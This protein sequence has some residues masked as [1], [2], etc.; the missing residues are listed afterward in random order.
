VLRALVGTKEFRQSKGAKLRDPAED[1]VASYRALG[2]T[3]AKP[4]ADGDAANAM[5]WQTQVVG[6][7]PM[8]W[9][10]PDGQPLDNQAWATPARALASMDV[11]WSL[12]GGWW[13]SKG[14]AYQSAAQWAPALP[15]TFAEVVDHLARRVHGTPSNS[16]VLKAACIAVGVDPGMQISADHMAL[17][18]K[19]NRL[20]GVLLDHPRHTTR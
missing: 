9:P 6:L 8:A 7:A 10:R 3:I 13:P 16:N 17:T 5:L 2:A 18:W 12:A 14:V 11:H 20:L 15:A 1:V 4:S 19:F